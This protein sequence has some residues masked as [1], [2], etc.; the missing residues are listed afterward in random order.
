M[1]TFLKTLVL[2]SFCTIGLTTIGSASDHRFEFQKVD[3]GYLRFDG[4]TGSI[5]KC[6]DKDGKI[7]CAISND[8]R[9]RY[10]QEI[11]TLNDKIA[12]LQQNKAKTSLPSKQDMDQA[13][14]TMKYF[15]DKFK[16]DFKNN[17]TSPDNGA[18]KL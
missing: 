9:A 16:N 5:D 14:D 11:K 13:Y 2:A 15:F 17:E 4:D 10:E 7:S 3:G 1:S 12:E 6:L 8:D 18:D